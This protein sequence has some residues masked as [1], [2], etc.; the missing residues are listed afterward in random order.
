MCCLNSLGLI[1][2][3]D[4]DCWEGGYLGI[5]GGGVVLLNAS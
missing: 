4:S 3:A 5:G 1:D 2:R